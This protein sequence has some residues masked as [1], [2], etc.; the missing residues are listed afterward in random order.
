[1]TTNQTPKRKR[2]FNPDEVRHFACGP[3]AQVCGPQSSAHRNLPRLGAAASRRQSPIAGDAEGSQ[4][5]LASDSMTSQSAAPRVLILGG[6]FAGVGAARKLA[7][8]DAEVVLVDSHDY[9]TFQPM[10]YQ[11]ATDLLDDAEVA[12]PLRDLFH[13]QPNIA[14]HMAT[15]TS[16]DLDSERGR[17]RLDGPDRVRLP[18]PGPWGAGQLLRRRGRGGA[19]LPDVHARRCRAAEEARAS[20]LG[21]GRSRPGTCRGWRPGDRRCRRW[22]DRGRERRRP[23]GALPKRLRQGL[24]EHAARSGEADSRRGRAGPLLDVRSGAPDL[25]ARHARGLG[26]R[27]CSWASRSRPSRRRG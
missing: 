1:M 4:R 20:P 16:L 6:G 22:A 14:V 15:A 24:S 2:Q 5:I 11:V 26:R 13:D 18:R 25:R 3:A 23:L 27:D 12:H 10:L 19:R 9:H 7:K 8:S 17:V 21:G